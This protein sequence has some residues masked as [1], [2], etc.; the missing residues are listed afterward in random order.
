MY[1]SA[2][3]GRPRAHHQEL[4]SCGS[5]LWFYRCSVVIAVVLV[6]VGPT[7]ALRTAYDEIFVAL[8]GLRL[9]ENFV[10]N[11]GEGCVRS[12]QCNVDFSNSACAVCLR[13]IT[14]ICVRWPIAPSGNILT[15]SQ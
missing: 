15:F 10:I 9:S 7:G 6:V 3:F 5:S 14:E 12:M 8:V 2:C 4:N 13:K 1:S 11:F